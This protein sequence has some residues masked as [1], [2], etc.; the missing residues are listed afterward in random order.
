MHGER[1]VWLV[2]V[3]PFY[4]TSKFVDPTTGTISV[5]HVHERMLMCAC[6]HACIVCMHIYVCTHV[7]MYVCLQVYTAVIVYTVYMGLRSCKTEYLPV[8]FILSEN[9]HSFS[10]MISTN[11]AG[12]K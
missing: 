7:C 4:F 12:V 8:K 9:G 2:R 5:V 11:L 6:V 1:T 10:D 3:Q